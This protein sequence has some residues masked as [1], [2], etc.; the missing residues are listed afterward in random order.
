MVS[1]KEKMPINFI[2]D[3]IRLLVECGCGTEEQYW[4]QFVPLEKD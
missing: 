1:R 4:Q 3:L 2:T